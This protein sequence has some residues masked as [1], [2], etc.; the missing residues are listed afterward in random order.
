VILPI[1]INEQKLSD[2]PMAFKSITERRP[3]LSAIRPKNG[4]RRRPAVVNT[5]ISLI[6][7][8]IKLK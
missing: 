5:T 2:S 4:A 6:S 3:L 1:S 7:Y 8:H